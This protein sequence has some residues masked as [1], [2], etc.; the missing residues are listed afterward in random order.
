MGVGS[1]RQSEGVRGWRGWQRVAL[2]TTSREGDSGGFRFG[3]GVRGTATIVGQGSDVFVA[4]K[5]M[6]KRRWG[7]EHEGVGMVMYL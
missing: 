7:R 2:A 3:Q 5:R 4:G 1:G 6:R